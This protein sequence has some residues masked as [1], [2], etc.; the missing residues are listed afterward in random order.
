MARLFAHMLAD[1]GTPQDPSRIIVVSSVAGTNV[2]HV[3]DH[4][5]IMYSASK[6]AAHHLAR[7]LAVELG[8]RNITTNTI[9]P[10]FF[11]SKLANGLIEILGGQDE[12]E[13][14]NPM[15]R[16]GIPEDIA[17]CVLYLCSK[18]GNYCNGEYISL[19]GGQR[20]AMGRQTKL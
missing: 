3:G 15:K 6:A 4:G 5:T 1:S 14:D 13:R 16:L 18:A 11:P 7:N 17:G 9:A 2:P 20:L 12:L 8:P 19:D 10:G